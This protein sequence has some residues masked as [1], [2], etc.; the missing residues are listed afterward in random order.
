MKGWIHL[1]GW[2]CDTGNTNTF[3]QAAKDSK[4]NGIR[5]KHIIKRTL[6]S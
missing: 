5:K 1:S 4:L 6:S 3:V 2:D